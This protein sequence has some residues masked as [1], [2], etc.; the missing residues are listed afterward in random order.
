MAEGKVEDDWNRTAL[1]ACILANSNRD[2]KKTKAYTVKDFH[3]MLKGKKEEL[4]EDTK[5]A[6]QLMKAMFCKGK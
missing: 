6:M 5:S 3:P 2:P 1:I 4:I